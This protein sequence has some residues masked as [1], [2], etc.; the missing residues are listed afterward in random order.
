[1]DKPAVRVHSLCMTLW[2][3]KYFLHKPPP[4]LGKHSKQDVEQKYL[5]ASAIHSPNAPGGMDGARSARRQ[6]ENM[7]RV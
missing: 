1:M 6:G 2:K 4:E 5:A 3:A 7:P